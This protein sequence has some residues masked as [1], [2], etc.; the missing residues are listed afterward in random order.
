MEIEPLKIARQI[1]GGFL[2]GTELP[3]RQS[4]SCPYLPGLTATCEAFYVE[5]SMD[6]AVHRA[7]MD[8]GF[9]RSGRVFYRPTCDACAKCIPY[10]VSTAVFKPSRSMR[11]VW[12]QNMDIRVAF[13]DRIPTPRK[14]EL[15]ARYLQVQHDGT[16]SGEPEEFI[17]FLYDS[18]VTGVEVCYYLGNRLVGVSIA[19][20]CPG[21]LSSVYMF[22]DP[23]QARRSLGTYSILWEVEHCRR[24]N[25]TYYYLGYWVPGSRTMDYKARFQPGEILDPKGRWVPWSKPQ[26]DSRAGDP[27]YR[28]GTP[29]A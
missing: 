15:F 5:D 2:E 14:H 28:R 6:D 27:K 21:A 8:R 25:C 3:T 7:F 22:F 18:P 9:R 12:R 20:L 19:D 23:D 10:R 26:P 13:G 16:M 4:T 1:V 24:Q 17:G 11:R 29:Q